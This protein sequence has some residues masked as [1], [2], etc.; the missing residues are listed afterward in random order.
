MIGIYK[1]TSPLDEVYIGQSKHID[2]RIKNHKRKALN[3]GLSESIAKFGWLS[4]KIEV[5]CECSI[6]EL[7]EK[8]AYYINY[9]AENGV[10]FNEAVGRPETGRN[11]FPVRAYK[12][13]IAEIRKQ[14]V[15]IN[16]QHE[17][18]LKPIKQK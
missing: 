16:Q 9:Y 6:E 2:L 18:N 3:K 4:H 12:E 13:T 8:E 17:L 15:I 10:V 7:N 5:V 14:A 11:T 1:I